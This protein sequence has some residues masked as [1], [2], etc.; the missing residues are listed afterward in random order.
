MVGRVASED[1]GE[2]RLH[3]HADERE[4]PARL[5]R[6]RR[7][8]LIGAEHPTD[9]FEGARRMTL[10]QVHREID[11]VTAR[12]ERGAEDRRIEA[13]V[14]HVDDDVGALH[15]RDADDRFFVAGVECARREPLFVEI[16]NGVRGTGRVDVGDDDLREDLG[17][18]HR[19]RHRAA[20]AAGSE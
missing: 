7:H 19:G 16:G 5:P 3:A 1:V 12:F 2:A 11:V 14:A 15:V 13:R 8:Q 6:S 4:Q 18:A 20:D 9:V 17:F 10:G